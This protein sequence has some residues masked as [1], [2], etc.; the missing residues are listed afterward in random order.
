MKK[1]FLIALYPIFSFGQ[2]ADLN[3]FSIVQIDSIA[4]ANGRYGSSDGK[5]KVKNQDGIV[6]GNGGSVITTYLFLP[7]KAKFEKLSKKERR[8]VNEY[9]NAKL[10]KG[11]YYQGV[12]YK[13]YNET[14]Y[15]QNYYNPTTE[16]FFTK[17]KITRKE[18]NKEAETLEYNLDLSELNDGK[19]IKNKFLI[20][21]KKFIKTINEQI[22]EFHKK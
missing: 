14:I 4:N 1:L 11:D 6:I 17:V 22:L 8:K 3:N 18:I 19:E 5:I 21:I 16:L 10:I 2:K 20:D 13:D 7:D 9:K 12:L 15:L